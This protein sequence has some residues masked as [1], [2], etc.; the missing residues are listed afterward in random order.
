MTS[1][2]SFLAINKTV[3]EKEPK[4]ANQSGAEIEAVG[5]DRKLWQALEWRTLQD[6][7]CP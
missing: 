6:Q 5:S 7:M 3:H 4:A 2:N 1:Q